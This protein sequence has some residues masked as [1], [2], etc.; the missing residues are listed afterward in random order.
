[1]GIIKETKKMESEEHSSELSFD[2]DDECILYEVPCQKEFFYFFKK[3]YNLVITDFRVLIMY[4]GGSIDR[5]PDIKR[6]ISYSRL[7]GITKSTK[8]AAT[9]FVIHVKNMEDECLYV[10]DINEPIEMIKK[11]YTSLAKK[12]LP[13]FG[14]DSNNLKDY[15]TT[16]KDAL[17][18]ISRMPLRRFRIKDERILTDED[19]SDDDEEDKE[20][21]NDFLIIEREEAKDIEKFLHKFNKPERLEEEQKLMDDGTSIRLFSKKVRKSR[22]LDDD[23]E[24]EED[25]TTNLDDFEILKVIDKGSFGKVFLVRNKHTEKLYAM[26][27]IRKDILIEKGQIQNTKNE[28]DILLSIE[29]P[30]LLGMDFVFQNDYRLYFFLDYIKGGNLFE[31]LFT[32]KR[33]PENVVKFFAAQLVLAIGCLHENKVVHRDLKP[34]NVL[35]GEDGY[36]KLADFG[37][38][39]FLLD[40][41]QSTYSFCGTAEYLAPEILDMKGHDYAVDWWTLG[42]LIYELRIGRPPFLDKNHQKLGRLI[43]KGKIIFPDPIRHKIDMT[44]ELKDIITKLLDRDPTSRLG[45][46]GYKEVM[47][48]KWFEDMDFDSLL[49]KDIDPPFKPNTKKKTH[50]PHHL[51]FGK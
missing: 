15:T 32:V 51:E 35:V 47:N 9:C 14:I 49:K 31:N 28:K 39:K 24:D 5:D 8:E 22:E 46:K 1:M 21:F 23:S 17:L 18:G 40:A 30:F 45:A 48:H 33:F 19:S 25:D 3:S 44:E 4:R 34:E 13:I 26:K 6:S 20:L 37:L 41:K 42:I 50:N 38:A 36:L 29:H 2:A 16:D 11:I 10:E 27:R 12:N 7:K 43:K